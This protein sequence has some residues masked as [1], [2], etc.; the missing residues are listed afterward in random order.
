MYRHFGTF[1]LEFMKIIRRSTARMT[2]TRVGLLLVA[3]IGIVTVS[4]LLVAKKFQYVDQK[5]AI[6]I[7]EEY[8]SN[9]EQNELDEAFGLYTTG[10][11]NKDG[12]VWRQTI[13][14]FDGK[15][16]DVRGYKLESSSLAP[17]PLHDGTVVPC[18]L[19]TFKVSRTATTSDEILTICSHQRG[20]DWG[21]A[22]HE[23]MLTD[24]G[25]HFEAGLTVVE[26]KIVTTK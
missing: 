17:I 9:L 23:I 2:K 25:E 7:G 13:V 1:N 19:V 3:G 15:T 8:F 11:L 14:D 16:G 18:V 5:P 6:A 12:K 26:K 24:T 4:G 10:F 22:G 21:I 20:D